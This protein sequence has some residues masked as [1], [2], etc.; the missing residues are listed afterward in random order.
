M[1][2]TLHFSDLLTHPVMTMSEK[3]AQ[4]T[5]SPAAEFIA[6]DQLESLSGRGFGDEALEYLKQHGTQGHFAHDTDRLRRLRR[7]IDIRV[8]PFLTLSY[9]M[10]FL[11][12]IL[13]N[14]RTAV[15]AML[16]LLSS[17]SSSRL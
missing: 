3:G 8:I 14:V 17:L 15:P 13:L 1:S 16:L 11:D 10:N 2:H 9:L 5:R 4:E 6:G 7:K 12:K